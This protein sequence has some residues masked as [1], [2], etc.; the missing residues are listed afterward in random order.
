MVLKI[1]SFHLPN[2][3]NVLMYAAEKQCVSA[4]NRKCIF[5]LFIR[6]IG[7]RLLNKLLAI[8]KVRKKCEFSLRIRTVMIKINQQ[9]GR[10]LSFTN[11]MHNLF[12]LY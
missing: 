9:R 12:I 11:L 4:Q 7:S 6:T 3:I 2:N 5:K 8:S 10:L 1:D